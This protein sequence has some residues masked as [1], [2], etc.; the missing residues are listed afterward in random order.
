MP[1]SICYSPHSYHLKMDYTSSSFKKINDHLCFT[2]IA[3]LF[4][5]TLCGAR[6]GLFS[7]FW[8]MECDANVAFLLLLIS[9]FSICIL[10]PRM[11]MKSEL[12]TF[13]CSCYPP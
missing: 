11:L 7:E 8:M 9:Q 1:P 13:N 3:I 4:T 2:I 5:F 6:H 12:C 10:T